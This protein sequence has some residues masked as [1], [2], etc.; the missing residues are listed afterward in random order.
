MEKGMTDIRINEQDT[1]KISKM[2]RKKLRWL[3]KKKH[4]KEGNHFQMTKLYSGIIQFIFFTESYYHYITSILLKPVDIF[5]SL[6]YLGY[7]QHLTPLLLLFSRL[8]VSDSLW[9][10]DCST[11]GF[12]VLHHLFE[13]AKTHVHWVGDATQP[14]RHHWPL[15]YTEDSPF[16]WLTWQCSPEV[17]PILLSLIS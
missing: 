5:L 2:G 10:M 1:Q 3:K 4:E 9:A 15:C 16:P 8:L 7:L 13:L 12:S 14:S 6:A 11:S 17:S